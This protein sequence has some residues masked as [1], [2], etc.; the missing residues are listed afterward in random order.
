MGNHGSVVVRP[1]KTQY[2]EGETVE[3]MARPDTGYCFAGWAG[4]VRGKRPVLSVAIDGNK[5]ITANFTPWQ[6][7]TGIPVPEFGIF[8]THHMYQGKTYDFGKGPEP[9]KDAGNGPYT[10]YVDNTHPNATNTDNPY[11]TASK[12]R[13]SFPGSNC[14][15]GSVIEM[16]GGPISFCGRL[17]VFKHSGTQARPIFIRGASTSE[18]PL[19]LA[20][21]KI[22]INGHHIIVEN[23]NFGSDVWNTAKIVVRPITADKEVHHVSIRHCESGAG[24]GAVSY[25]DGAIAEDIVFYNNHIHLYDM[26]PP[27]VDEEPDRVGVSINRGSN[28][29][30]IVD[31]HIH[32]VSGDCVASGHDAQYSASNYYIGRNILHDASENAV[33][34]KEIDTAIVSENAMY[35]FA[36]GSSGSGGGGTAMVIHYGPRYSPKNVWVLNNEIYNATSTGIQVGGRQIHDVHI[37]GNLIHDISNGIVAAYMFESYEQD[38]RKIY[39]KLLEKGYVSEEGKVADSFSG[40]DD[41]FQSWFPSDYTELPYI[42]AL[43]YRTLNSDQTATGYRT[44]SSNRVYLIGNTFN[45]IDNGVYSH[46]AG[47]TPALFMYNNI[48]SNVSTD[49]YHMSLWG[50]GHL[51]NSAISHNILYQPQDGARIV[52]GGAL[53][54]IAEFQSHT[55]KGEGC[56]EAN[57]MFVDSGKNNFN[58]QASSPA[59][60]AGIDHSVYQSFPDTYGIGIR[61]DTNRISRPQSSSWDIGAREYGLSTINDLSVLEAAQNSVTL[62]WTVPGEQGIT[63]RPTGYDLRYASSTMTESNWDAATHVQGEPVAD[64]FGEE[65]SFTVT[66]LDSTYY[67]AIKTRDDAGN[68]STLSNTVSGITATNGNHAPVLESIGSRLIPANGTLV[69]TVSATDTDAGDTLTY[70]AS[71]IPTGASFNA[72]SRAFTWTP[73]SSQSGT[74]YVDFQVSDSQ[75]TV[76]ETIRITVNNRAPVLAAIGAQSVTEKALLRFL[77]RAADAD[78][79]MLAYTATGLPPGARFTNQVFSWTP[80]NSQSGTYEVSFHVSDGLAADAETIKITVNQVFN[81]A[82][83]LDLIGSQR[84]DEKVRLDFAVS[85]TDADGDN[86][87]YSATGLPSGATFTSQ[88]F[89]WTPTYDQ[90]G[91]YS[92]TFAVSDGELRDSEQVAITVADEPTPDLT[93][94]GVHGLIP[95]ADAV[96]VPLNSM[97]GLSIS[98]ASLGMDAYTVSIQLDG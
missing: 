57:P 70:S 31:N 67:F 77:V 76:S 48:I 39:S 64:D 85:A 49:G 86:L 1:D 89:S 69:F 6:P 54:G 33:D 95:S 91:S 93:A 68:V 4:D 43:L 5:T 22:I 27:G 80:T 32:H 12:P 78:A 61:V 28:R 21:T 42:E 84:V 11:G 18:M 79:D 83:V 56:L 92:V 13:V 25:A 94:P 3:L 74:Y 16:H 41:E 55:G 7:P 73:T 36:G 24:M 97:I 14:G 63:G 44:W 65:Q 82:P 37:I 59:I 15:P 2:D 75:I 45:S 62:N 53:Y 90:A 29:I 81:R 19:I 40:L 71:G 23:I 30:W 52:W 96:Q 88:S 26:V 58:L 38:T 87:T 72:A 9:Y 47:T 34:L 50:S 10:H 51:A 8:E 60:D 66:D 98:D 17:H 35:N 46:V 20:N